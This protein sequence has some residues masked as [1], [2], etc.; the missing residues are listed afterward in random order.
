[1][2]GGREAALQEECRLQELALRLARTKTA[3]AEEHAR[4]AAENARAA[5]ANARAA[6]ENARAEIADLLH[7][8]EVAK[9]QA[10]T[11]RFTIMG[12]TSLSVSSNKPV[13]E[14][15]GFDFMF[16]QLSILSP[17]RA[18]PTMERRLLASPLS[19]SVHVS[20]A[21]AF[22]SVDAQGERTGTRSWVS[23]R[24]ILSPPSMSRR[25]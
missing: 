24:F 7:K 18:K 9:L 21:A 11:K 13:G 25:G 14:V 15:V 20:V 22:A 4:T 19:V 17:S 12:T 10:E 23:I 16:K 1:M 6:E 2:E 8:M 3:V 5:E